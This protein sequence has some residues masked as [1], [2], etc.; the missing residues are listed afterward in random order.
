MTRLFSGQLGEEIQARFELTGIPFYGA[1]HSG[2]HRTAHPVVGLVHNAVYKSV[3][4]A[5]HFGSLKYVADPR[6]VLS[7]E[8]RRDKMTKGQMTQSVLEQT[9]R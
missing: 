5:A 2:R 4:Y 3:C 1:P 8:T 6:G 7:S 9:Y